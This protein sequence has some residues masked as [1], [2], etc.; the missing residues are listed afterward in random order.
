MISGEA[1][2]VM[3]MIH[4]QVMSTE[5]MEIRKSIANILFSFF[6]LSLRQGRKNL[7]DATVPVKAAN[8]A[9]QVTV[10][11]R[12]P[13]KIGFCIVLG[14]QFG[15]KAKVIKNNDNPIQ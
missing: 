13:S 7:R 3:A 5:A 6:L 10:A 8:K 1:P 2:F 9:K 12:K 4:M 11:H 15:A 14:K